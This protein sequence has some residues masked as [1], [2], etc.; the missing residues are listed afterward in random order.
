LSQS[1]EDE[2]LKQNLTLQPYLPLIRP[3]YKIKEED[4]LQA[5]LVY[6]GNKISL[7]PE[8]AEILPVDKILL[9]LNVFSGQKLIIPEKTII[10]EG[11]KDIS[12]YFSL[13]VNPTTEEVMRLAR[14]HNLTPQT[15]RGVAEKLSNL[16]DKPNP[17]KNQ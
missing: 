9:F 12:I 6:L 3:G 8:L 16:L 11:L 1:K 15:I 4:Y 17:L 2:V 5:L 14:L 7:L 13:T 10:E